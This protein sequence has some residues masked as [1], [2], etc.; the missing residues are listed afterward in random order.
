MDHFE[1][2]PA[3]IF[4]HYSRIGHALASPKR[5]EILEL[6]QQGPGNVEYLASRVE[7]TF[8]NTSRHLQ[9]L[10]E[11]KFVAGKREGR[12][13]TYRIANS[14]VARFLENL[15]SFADAHFLEIQQA[16]RDFVENRI[17]FDPVTKEELFRRMRDGE[18]I[19][20][21]VRP[22][23][24]YEAGHLL[25]AVSFPLEELERKL[26]CLPKDKEIVAYCRGPH[27]V[28]SVEAVRLLRGRGYMVHRMD[29]D[30]E[31]F[32]QHGFAVTEK[33]SA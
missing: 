27:C 22:S 26:D 32:K 11:A 19:A 7:G 2:F 4:A 20:I 21:D 24:E 33:E 1:K 25:G 12:T 30:L 9:I 10:R 18:A 14:A 29:C 28:L 3:E 31:A 17:G 6:L 16:R 23:E 5:L 13:V 8:A 15:R